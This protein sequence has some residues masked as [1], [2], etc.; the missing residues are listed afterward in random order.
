MEPPPAPSRIGSSRPGLSF[1]GIEN[2]LFAKTR[3]PPRRFLPKHSIFAENHSLF[4]ASRTC[5]GAL[6][7][8]LLEIVGLLGLLERANRVG[9]R[10]VVAQGRVVREHLDRGLP[11]GDDLVLVL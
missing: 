5:P 6:P 4:S 3:K 11:S 2:N 7:S 9:E 1:N 10:G 8:G